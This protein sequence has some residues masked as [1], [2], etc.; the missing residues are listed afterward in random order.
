MLP[1]V[2][3][4]DT[5]PR[6]DTQK[7][8]RRLL[9]FGEII[10]IRRLDE[11]QGFDVLPYRWIRSNGIVQ[12]LDIDATRKTYAVVEEGPDEEIVPAR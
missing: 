10:K 2:P 4:P 5:P 9:R 11:L 8:R 7:V 12:P 1:R 6:N 3:Y